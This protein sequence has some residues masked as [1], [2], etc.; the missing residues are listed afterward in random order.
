[1]L[2]AESRDNPADRPSV[3]RV[4][5]SL[6]AGLLLV[7]CIASAFAVVFAAHEARERFRELEQLRRAENEIQVEWRQLLLERSTQSSHARVETIAGTEL[8]MVPP[9]GPIRTVVADQ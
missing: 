1:M 2:A 6:V 8:G 7:L 9:G 5:W 4:R 3:A